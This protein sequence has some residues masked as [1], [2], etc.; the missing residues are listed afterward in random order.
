MSTTGQCCNAEGYGEMAPASVERMAALLNVTNSTPTESFF[1]LGSGTGRL[2]MHMA[3]KGY[4]RLATGVE[5]NGGRHAFAIELAASALPQGMPFAAG[6]VTD[7]GVAIIHKKPNR[8]DAQSDSSAGVEPVGVHLY[9]GNMLDANIST[10]TVLYMNPACLSCSTKR[11]LLQK[12]LR[13]SLQL[14]Y[15]LTTS[16]LP[17]LAESGEFKEVTTELLSPMIGYEWKVPVTLYQRFR[18]E[19]HLIR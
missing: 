1:D 13:E 8:N 9:H 17:G 2:V 6:N 11:Q 12:I 4:A 10:A 7:S 5:L 14:Q 18:S 15:I 19:G 3:V 16:P